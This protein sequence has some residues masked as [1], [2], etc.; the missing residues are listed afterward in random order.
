[1]FYGIIILGLELG[2]FLELNRLT[3]ENFFF[4]YLYRYQP[5]NSRKNYT[6]LG[7]SRHCPLFL[8]CFYYKIN[9]SNEVIRNPI[10]HGQER[11]QEVR[12]A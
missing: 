10:D 9:I 6:Y 7:L 3:A 12:R 2:I 4:F 11:K 5:H 1:M 8:K